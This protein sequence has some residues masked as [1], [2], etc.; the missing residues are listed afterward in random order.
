MSI[1]LIATDLD[2]TLLQGD[3]LT[4]SKQNID[5]ITHAS[6]KGV[7][8]A[9]A[10]GRTWGVMSNIAGQ[11]PVTN[12]AVLSNGASA[13]DINSRKLIP[14]REIP[15]KLWHP[16]YIYLKQNNCIPEIYY[17]GKSYLEQNLLSSYKSPYIKEDFTNELKSYLTGVDNLENYLVNKPIEK[18]NVLFTPEENCGQV[19]DTLKIS[20][21]IHIT[22]SLPGNIEITLKGVNKAYALKRLCLDLDISNEEV[23]VFG[24]ADNDIEMLK[25][26]KWSFAMEN[27]DE[28]IRKTAH[29]ITDSNTKDGVAKAIDKYILK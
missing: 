21:D 25:W 2:G 10:T 1:K 13:Y 5:A 16:I 9:I 6:E 26:A 7:L 17:N 8:F 24:D 11:V 14:L 4:V 15:F 23:M 19:Y 3:H 29:F 22:S 28:K 18:I 27:A 12:Y 20:E